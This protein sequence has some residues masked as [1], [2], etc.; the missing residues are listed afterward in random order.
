MTQATKIATAEAIIRRYTF[1]DQSLLWEAL[2]MAGSGVTSAGGRIVADGNKRL[3]VLGDTSAQT[4]LSI[5]WRQTGH[6]KG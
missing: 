3:A 5:Q 4:V 1:D 2:Q 6:S